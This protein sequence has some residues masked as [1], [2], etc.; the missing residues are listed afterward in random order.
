MTRSRRPQVDH[1]AGGGGSATTGGRAASKKK[2]SK[3]DAADAVA[4]RLL[5]EAERHGGGRDAF[6]KALKRVFRDMDANDDGV[7]T[8]KEVRK[9]LAE[10]G[11]LGDDKRDLADVFEAMDLDGDGRVDYEEM[12]DFLME[13][14]GA[15]DD[16]S[17][18]RDD[19]SRRRD[20]YD[21]GSRRKRSP[22]DD[23]SRASKKH[24]PRAWGLSAPEV[25]WPSGSDDL[26]TAVETTTLAS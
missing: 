10:S 21:D 4:E 9:A 16:D 2:P 13:R 3:V 11:V 12:I 8:K 24:S 23:D 25:G 5:K 6:R 22:R 14:A 15:K 17:R 1:A 20:E 18:R 7:L 19:D 26:A